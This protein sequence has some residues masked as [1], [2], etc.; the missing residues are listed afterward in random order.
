[1]AEQGKKAGITA[2]EV[3]ND[4]A[5]RIK[6][7]EWPR[8]GTEQ[9]RR[10]L[11]QEQIREHYD[12]TPVTVQRAI[13]ILRVRGLIVTR[14][15]GGSFIRPPK[16]LRIT[17]PGEDEGS[18]NSSAPAAEAMAPFSWVMDELGL[19][20]SDEV[21]RARRT[22]ARNGVVYAILDAYT[23]TEGTE[24]EMVGETAPADRI[25]TWLPSDEEARLLGMPQEVPVLALL[26]R[27]EGGVVV[28]IFPGDRMEYR[29][30]VEAGRRS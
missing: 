21:H 28:R 24:V 22:L 8:E 29:P 17:I 18:W 30:A 20:E 2:N 27:V 12:T 4:L 7:G 19:S 23:A 11:T 6:A 26:N 16:P 5:Q 15:G 14:P 3:A 1:M 13:R 10:F 25:R 9:E